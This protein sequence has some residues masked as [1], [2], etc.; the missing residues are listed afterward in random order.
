MLIIAS[1]RNCLG[2]VMKKSIIGISFFAAIPVWSK[3]ILE[4]CIKLNTNSDKLALQWQKNSVLLLHNI[5][6][7]IIYLAAANNPSLTVKIDPQ[8]WSVL[9]PPHKQ[10]VNFNCIESKP[11]SEQRISC[12]NLVQACRF[13]YGQGL[14]NIAK[15]KWLLSDVTLD[16]VNAIR[17][18]V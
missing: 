16:R 4:D 17:A 3:A 9:L 14:E 11:G 12:K 13:D 18:V 8:K 1:L 15:G 7:E 5:H 10:E 6:D 2:V